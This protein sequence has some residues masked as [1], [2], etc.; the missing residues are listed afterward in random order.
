M[1]Q[2][3]FSFIIACQEDGT[4]REFLRRCLD[5]IH[6]QSCQD[7]EVLVC[8]RG[9]APTEAGTSAKLRHVKAEDDALRDLGIRE[10]RGEYLIH[11]TAEDLLYDYALDTIIKTMQT[12]RR[13]IRIDEATGQ[14]LETLKEQ[15]DPAD[16]GIYIFS[17]I[18]VGVEC[19]GINFWM[20]AQN[21][22]RYGMVL[23]GRPAIPQILAVMQMA[24]RRDLWLRYGGWYDKSANGHG[25]MY[26]RFVAENWSRCVPAILGEHW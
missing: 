10:A 14:Y 22:R 4:N 11:L 3:L 25:E 6:R 18:N 1:E 26:A 17:I 12:P 20:N 13:K 5:S 7:F 15:A 16:T 19:D 23:T 9:E 8:H 21:D 2:P 24:I